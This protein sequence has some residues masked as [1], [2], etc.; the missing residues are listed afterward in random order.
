MS[1]TDHLTRLLDA[2]RATTFRLLAPLDDDELSRQY[3][4]IM[5][6]L[7]WDYGHVGNYEELWLLRHLGDRSFA[8]PRMDQ[9]YDAFENPRWTRSELPLLSRAEATEFLGDVRAAVLRML[10]S[11]EPDPSE[12]LLAD[13]YVYQLVVQH[14]AQHQETMLQAL[15]LR[16]E[17]VPYQPA[18]RRAVPAPRPVDDT[19]RVV[20]PG[21][22]YLIGTDDRAAAYDNERP[23][24]RV[25]L[26]AFAIDRFPVT[27]RRYAAFIAGGGYQ[28]PELWTERGWQWLSDNGYGA[29]QGWVP[30]GHDGWLLRRFH[31][32]RPVDP[33]EPVVHVS[34]FEADAFARWAGGRLPTEA[35]W[36]AAATHDPAQP[37]RP[38]HHPWG[39]APPSTA[40]A[41]VG[42]AGW[43]P[44]P[45]GSF[46]RGA[47]ALGVEQ[48]IG[49]CYEWT[50]S[51]FAAYP[52]FAMFPYPEY[53]EVFF[54]GDYR[55]LRGASW[56][57]DPSVARASFRN[58]DHPYRRQIFAGFRMAW[59]LGGAGS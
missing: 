18:A 35:E 11:T 12:P 34:W 2:G 49:D 45:V 10:R 48:M 37:D 41:N 31:H 51:P 50:A 29:P 46:P 38:R 55:V 47:S 4:P 14:E 1:R 39:Q 26:A 44:A 8:D 36:E 24:H 33:A 27:C 57:S 25:Q 9:M 42:R 5:S 32:V 30:D 19:D 59:D 7:V 43:G 23:R 17:A 15:D 54:G 58:W 22:T 13:D 21:W 40:V 6:P 28:R 56:A 16:S 3:D 52:G 53:S 20:V